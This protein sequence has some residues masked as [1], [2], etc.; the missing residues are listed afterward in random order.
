MLLSFFAGL[1]KIVYS[2]KI[3]DL[4]F[5]FPKY[6]W[7]ITWSTSVRNEVYWFN[8][9][10][11]SKISRKTVTGRILEKKVIIPSAFKFLV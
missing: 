11:A 8:F 9:P 7:K 1:F 10:S 6:A 4:K 3:L 2:L 5:I